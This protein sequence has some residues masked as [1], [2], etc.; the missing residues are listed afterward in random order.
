M[1]YEDYCP[2]CGATLYFV[3]GHTECLTCHTVVESCCEGADGERH[4]HLPDVP[5]V[6]ASDAA[7]L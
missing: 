3:R 1:S 7:S 4:D 6:P 5:A 2:A